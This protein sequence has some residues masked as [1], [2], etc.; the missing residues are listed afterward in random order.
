M[1]ALAE[2]PYKSHI[3]LTSRETVTIS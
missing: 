1:T 3:V 2:V